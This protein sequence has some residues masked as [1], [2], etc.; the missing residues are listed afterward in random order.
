VPPIPVDRFLRSAFGRANKAERQ[1]YRVLADAASDPANTA[2]W[3]RVDRAL[4]RNDWAS[5]AQIAQIVADRALPALERV[6]NS[7]VTDALQAAGRTEAVAID[8]VF[9]ETNPR[10]IAFARERSSALV[11]GVTDQQ[12]AALK[13]VVARAT[14]GELTPAGAA[15]VIRGIV[16]L[17]ERRTAALAGFS[18]RTLGALPENAT[19]A[20]RQRAERAVDRYRDRLLRERASVIAQTEVMRSQNWGRVEAWRQAQ[21]R[22]LLGP[23]MVKQWVLTRD[24]HLCPRCRAMAG[25]TAEVNEPFQ[26]GDVAPPLHP[27]CRCTVRLVRRKDRSVTPPIEPKPI[28]NPDPLPIIEPKPL[29]PLPPGPIIPPA[30][31]PVIIEPPKP[32]RP[33]RVRKPKLAPEPVVAPPQPVATKEWFEEI[34]TLGQGERVRKQAM[35]EVDALRDRIKASP[36]P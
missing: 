18:A 33:P 11:R 30:P 7:M 29:P 1:I 34:S 32:P 19:Q 31:R 17:D 14:T 13:V 35:E 12:R 15:R 21:E 10:A 24:D 4:R 23:D 16:G 26:G 28:V 25:R 3:N 5:A 22:G 20:A 6:A 27:R 2:Q 9:A 8:G 36:P